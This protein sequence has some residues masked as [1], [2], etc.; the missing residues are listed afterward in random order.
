MKI[1]Y[2]KRVLAFPFVAI[3]SLI[4]CLLLYFVYLWNFIR[5]GGEFITYTHKNQRKTIKD[6]YNKLEQYGMEGLSK[7]ESNSSRL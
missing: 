7:Q 5:F 2:I 6:I 1:E 3:L 4:S